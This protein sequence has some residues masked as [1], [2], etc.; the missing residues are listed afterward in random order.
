MGSHLQVVPPISQQV[1]ISKTFANAFCGSH[2]FDLTDH[3]VIQVSERDQSKNMIFWLTP[4]LKFFFCHSGENSIWKKKRVTHVSYWSYRK[5]NLHCICI[6][7]IKQIWLAPNTDLYF[8]YTGFIMFNDLLTVV[9]LNAVLPHSRQL[10]AFWIL[11]TWLVIYYSS[12]SGTVK[13]V[14]SAMSMLE[15]QLSNTQPHA[16]L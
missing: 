2:G 15:F 12:W 10:H 5:Q 11:W 4:Q 9:S 1:F 6:I 13:L 8:T 16:E 14:C 7:L 3:L